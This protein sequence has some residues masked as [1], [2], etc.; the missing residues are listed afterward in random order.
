MGSVYTYNSKT[1]N[2]TGLYYDTIHSSVGCDSFITL[3]LQFFYNTKNIQTQICQG[4]S[5]NFLGSILTQSGNYQDTTHYFNSCDTIINLQLIVI[6]SFNQ[7]TISKCSY[8]DTYFFGHNNLYVPGVYFD[9]STVN[10]C[11]VITRLTLNNDSINDSIYILGNKIYAYDNR[12]NINYEWHDN[13]NNPLVN[14]N[15]YVYQPLN[16]GYF[17]ALISKSSCSVWSKFI[18]FDSLL[19]GIGNSLTDDNHFSIYP[20]PVSKSLIISS[21]SLVNTIEITDVLGRVC[22]I[23]PFERG[24]GDYYLNVETLSSGIYFIKAT[25]TKGNVMNGKFVKE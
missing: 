19:N 10:G 22:S 21:K 2:T 7:I 1:Y 24:Q 5:Y 6:D 18:Y 13:I 25:N 20:N 11:N 15:N 8:S 9:T 17:R 23:P 14:G 12:T 16:T 3:N 4:S